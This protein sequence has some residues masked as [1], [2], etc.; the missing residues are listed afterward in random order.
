MEFN[1]IDYRKYNFDLQYLS[2]EQL[3]KHYN[4]IGKYQMRLCCTPNNFSKEKVY[5]FTTKYG[6]YLSL[7][8]K[9]IL[10]KN[11]I[12]S[13]I[14]YEINPAN[15]NLHI[16]MFSQKVK[17]FPRKYILYQLE[18]KDISNFIN[19]RYELS[20][21]HS[22]ETWDY[23]H[24]N[25]NKFNDILRKK[26]S[27]LPI[28][29]IPYRYLIY[30]NINSYNMPYKRNIIFFGSIN[31]LREKKINYLNSKLLKFGYS[32]KVFSNLFG[33]DL[34]KEILNSVIILNIHNYN[35]G[36]LE[37][38]RLNEILSCNRLVIS[39]KPDIRID[40]YNYSIYSEK[41]VFVNSLDEMVEKIIYYLKNKNKYDERLKVKIQGLDYENKIIED[42]KK[43]I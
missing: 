25:I 29:L 36:I 41:V 5:I 34:F 8:L 26:I 6:Y 37:T 39:E 27:Y 28:P 35:N 42:V 7:V 9:Y 13:E 11:L 43:Y 19:A 17:Q 4:E 16:I 24:S 18:Q 38:N 21:L 40:F 20:I 22:Q 23:S 30:Q 3:E 2:D 1:L 31:Y 15:P 14:I 33:A 32:I 12:P 10:F